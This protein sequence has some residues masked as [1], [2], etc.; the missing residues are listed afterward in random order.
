MLSVDTLNQLRDIYGDRTAFLVGC[1]A[2][3]LGDDTCY[4]DVAVYPGAETAKRILNLKEKVVVIPLNSRKEFLKENTVL[5]HTSSFDYQYAVEHD[6]IKYY[7]KKAL[8]ALKKA[9]ENY[10]LS[11]NGGS[12]FL[13]ASIM[14][15]VDALLFINK[16]EPASSHVF[17]QVSELNNQ[18][19]SS[20]IDAA[21]LDENLGSL[22]NA[23]ANMVSKELG[24]ADSAV[25]SEKISRFMTEN[26]Q[27]EASAYL[28]HKLSQLPGDELAMLNQ[29]MKLGFPS[30]KDT[31]NVLSIIKKTSDKLS[32]LV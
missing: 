18:E 15:T 31:K 11:K 25:F 3:G 32:T 26:R 17:K 5:I 30:E 6:P 1:M 20:A 24:P 2:L 8:A 13:K 27:V 19:S 23:R 10:L 14:N 7:R 21:K 28:Y 22:L 4:Y 16:T 29:R 12:S 9:M